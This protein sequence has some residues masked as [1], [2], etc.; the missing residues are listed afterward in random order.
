MIPNLNCGVNMNH[1]SAGAAAAEG[2]LAMLHF[3]GQFG[4]Q[5]T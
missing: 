4:N 1:N 3:L 2:Y 5:T